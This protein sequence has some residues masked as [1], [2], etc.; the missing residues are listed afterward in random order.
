MK[1]LPANARRIMLAM[2][3]IAGD[4]NILQVSKYQLIQHV[5]LADPFHPV[6]VLIKNGYLE[7]IP[8]QKGAN[9]Y[10]IL[11]RLEE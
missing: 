1:K 2:Q 9:V 7:K 11:K 5:A 10:K 3:K 8:Q 6:K 4:M